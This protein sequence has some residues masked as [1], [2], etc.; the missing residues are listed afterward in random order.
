MPLDPQAQAFLA[1]VANAPPLDTCTIEQNR[2]Q[3]AAVVAFR[4]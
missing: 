1:M 3:L 4:P 2:A